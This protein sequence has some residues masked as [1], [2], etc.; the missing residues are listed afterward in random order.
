LGSHDDTTGGIKLSEAK[1]RRIQDEI[2]ELRGR[3]GNVRPGDLASLAEKVGRQGK[4]GRH[5][6][7]YRKPGRPPI[8]ISDH[9][10]TMAKGTVTGILDVIQE[11]LDLILLAG[12]N[13]DTED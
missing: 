9:P 3:L 1:S 8:P 6:R 11:D 12:A 4:P 13:N 10:G 5:Q 7:V 2:D